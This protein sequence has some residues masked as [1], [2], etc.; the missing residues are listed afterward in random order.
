MSFL[1]AFLASHSGTLIVG[2]IVGLFIAALYFGVKLRRA[3]E[4]I[5]TALRDARK[6]VEGAG[7]ERDVPAKFEA[8]TQRLSATGIIGSAWRRFSA[9]LLLPP[10][11]GRPIQQT[12]PPERFFNHGL[13][14]AANLNARLQ[15]AMPNLLVGGG[16]LLTFIGLMIALQAAGGSV[17][18][19]DVAQSRGALQVLL[20][21]ASLKFVSSLVGLC[22]SIAYLICHRRRLHALDE[23]LDGFCAALNERMPPVS[24]HFLAQ[25]ANQLLDQQLAA[26]QR[27]VNDLV[28]S[29]GDRLD[30]SLS[31]HLQGEIGPLRAAIERMADGMAQMNQD[32]LQQMVERFGE[33]LKDTAGGQ[34]Q[35]LA[36]TLNGLSDG[37]QGM[38]VGFA[39]VQERFE[40]V[41]R[42]AAGDLANTAQTVAERLQTGAEATRQAMEQGS[43]VAQEAMRVTAADFASAAHAAAERLAAGADTARQALEQGGVAAQ[44]AMRAAAADFASRLVPLHEALAELP[45]GLAQ[46]TAA[47]AAQTASAAALSERMQPAADAMQ[48][49]AQAAQAA[50]DRLAAVAQTLAALEGALRGVTAE[51]ATSQQRA[52]E[53]A[54]SLADAAR[55]FEGLDQRLARVVAELDAGL[56]KLHEQIIRFVTDVDGKTGHAVSALGGQIEDLTEAL[57]GSLQ[58][59]TDLLRRLQKVPAE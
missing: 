36:S 51:Q 5:L 39:E 54:S 35:H 59:L 29:L 23:A 11:P 32:A 48:H 8:L 37:L 47:L 50:V 41:G 1:W 25:Q 46:A 3:T 57:E 56:T 44:S 27:L 42:S 31:N 22:L 19:E 52:A 55:R 18:A 24:P 38:R 7:G 40:A 20:N 26:Q 10:Q 53:L 6:E 28:L 16:L 17:G 4:R 13:L 30:A 15:A 21:A 33:L 45:A 43:A 12:Q 2:G 58:P 34:L 49:A 9:T 14:R